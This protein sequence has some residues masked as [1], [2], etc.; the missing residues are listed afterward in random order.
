MPPSNTSGLAGRA[1]VAIWHDIAPEGLGTFYEWHNRE[2]MPERLAIPGFQRGRRYIRVAGEG[3]E[4]FNLYEVDSFDVLVGPDYLARLNAPTPWTKQAVAHFRDV[5]RGLCRVAGSL[6]TGQGGVIATLRFAV[7]MGRDAAMR[8]ML[9]DESIPALLSQPGIVGAHAGCADTAG[10]SIPTA[11][12]LARQSPTDIPSWVMLV[13]GI[14]HEH[15]GRALPAARCAEL[16][17]L[18]GVPDEPVTGFYRLEAEC[19]GGLQASARS[20]R[21]EIEPAHA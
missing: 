11:E 9:A 12:K 1:F 21:G 8:Q 15:L 2:H 7:S 16:L 3:Q 4:F 20:S 13:E 17:A 10:S 5:T 18:G 14:S 6:G 19:L